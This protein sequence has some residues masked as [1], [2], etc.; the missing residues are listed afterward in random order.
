MEARLFP[1]YRGLQTQG[2]IPASREGSDTGGFRT[3]LGMLRMKVQLQAQ[4]ILGE[5]KPGVTSVGK[6]WQCCS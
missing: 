5:P 6:K 3:G 4:L 2:V 1:G